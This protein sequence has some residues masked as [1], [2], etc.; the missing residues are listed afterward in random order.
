MQSTL[1]ICS[2]YREQLYGVIFLTCQKTLRKSVWEE[3]YN[4]YLMQMLNK[5]VYN[6]EIVF[7]L[8]EFSNIEIKKNMN[9]WYGNKLVHNKRI[10]LLHL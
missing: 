9:V 3:R 4:L 6:S 1:L 2:I 8:L 5:L 10:Q 7:Q